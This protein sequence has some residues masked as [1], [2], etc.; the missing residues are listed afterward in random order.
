MEI[1]T[2]C[3]LRFISADY[4]IYGF[5]FDEF[6]IL[7]GSELLDTTIFTQNLIT[8]AGYISA[9]EFQN[10]PFFYSK[11]EGVKDDLPKLADNFHS[12]LNKLLHFIWL[13]KDC[14]VNVGNL[15]SFIPDS[16]HLM[17][18][19]KL[20]S[21]SSSVGD[22]SETVIT[23]EDLEHALAAYNQYEKLGSESSGVEKPE[24]PYSARAV[25]SDSLYHYVD[26]NKNTR[27]ERAISFLSM[28]R[29][30]SFLPLK[31]SLYMSFLECLFTTDRQEVTH[32]VCERVALYLGGTYELKLNT[33][34]AVK[35]A[36]EIRSGFFH[37]QE[38]DKKHD[39]RKKLE[40]Q[41][42]TID[43]LLRQIVNKILFHDYEIFNSA[44]DIRK[45][46]FGKLVLG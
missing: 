32:K 1:R 3:G 39:S 37:G 24:A 34:N 14:S 27:I 25:I 7:K 8:Q 11:T 28:A 35:T 33:Y 9:R 2:I 17:S 16:V 30:N 15:Y 31:I 42:F 12:K 21:F 36:Y 13:R 40:Q 43:N 23:K 22:F 19:K 38:I 20:A 41:S 45:D 44:N 5:K 10:Y 46:F 6:E 4:S 26:Y 18:S 29:S